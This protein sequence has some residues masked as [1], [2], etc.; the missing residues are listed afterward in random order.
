MSAKNSELYR[1]SRS[2]FLERLKYY[3]E[4]YE[5]FCN[6]KDQIHFNKQFDIIV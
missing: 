3:P 4:D 5:R 1:V 6:I 2:K